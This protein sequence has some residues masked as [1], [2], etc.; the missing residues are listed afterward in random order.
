MWFTALVPLISSIL[1]ENGPLGKYFKLKTD[2]IV[3]EQLFQLEILKAKTKEAETEAQQIEDRLNS[4]TQSFKQ[5]TF[6]FIAV[7]VVITMCPWTSTFAITM[8]ANF[9]LIPEWFQI[10]FVSV[11]SSIWGLPIAKEYLGGMFK[12]LGNA[13]ELKREYK[14]RVNREAFFNSVRQ[15]PEFKKQGIA[16]RMVDI[17]DTAIDRGEKTIENN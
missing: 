9:K 12:S 3:A 13:I 8:W 17:L 11:Y 16:Q 14:I 5:S 10:L 15:E 1:G 2:K 6:W 7:P 4:T